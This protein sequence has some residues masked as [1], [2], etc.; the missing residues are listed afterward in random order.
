[1]ER[2]KRR[3]VGAVKPVLVIALIIAIYFAFCVAGK[4]AFGQELEIIAMDG[5]LAVNQT[6]VEDIYMRASRYLSQLGL[7]LRVKY[8]RLDDNPCLQFHSF[9]L[10]TEELKCLAQQLPARPY[11]VTYWLTPP[12]V[13]VNQAYGPQTAWIAGI[14]EICGHNATGNATAR[15]Y[16]DGTFGAPT[17]DH[18]ATIM[19]HEIAHIFCAKHVESSENLMHPDANSFTTKYRG[20]LPVLRIT[21][22]QVKRGLISRRKLWQKI[23]KN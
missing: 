18:S 3:S 9:W 22:R 10:R 14:A 4:Y 21:K 23:M 17:Y 5:Y 6:E 20:A 13:V 12:M 11:V 15:Q 2:T 7:T 16:V 19:A 1:M 8:A